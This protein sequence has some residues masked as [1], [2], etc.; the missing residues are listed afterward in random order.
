M[1]QVPPCLMFLFL[2][3]TLSSARGCRYSNIYTGI[4]PAK[5]LNCTFSH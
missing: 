2:P 3:A 4:S 5:Y 1:S